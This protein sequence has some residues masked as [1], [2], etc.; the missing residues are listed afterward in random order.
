MSHPLHRAIVDKIANGVYRSVA[1]DRKQHLLLFVSTR[2]EREIWMYC[3]GLLLDI[4]R[5]NLSS[6]ILAGAFK[7]AFGITS[8]KKVN[9]SLSQ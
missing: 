2:K 9:N 6:F 1:C 5:K 4:Y 8:S 7:Y 3:V